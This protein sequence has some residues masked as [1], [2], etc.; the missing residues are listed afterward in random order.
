VIRIVADASVAVKW[1]VRDLSSESYTE[2]ALNLL[3]QVQRREVAL[4][5]PPHWMAEVAAVITRVS[6][7]TAREDIR[8]LH[9]MRYEVV[10]GPSVYAVACDL[11]RELGH[12]LFDT[13]YHA[14][15]L[16]R[17]DTILVTADERYYRKARNRGAIIR[18]SEYES[19]A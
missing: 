6:P 19:P 12:H 16:H 17:D 11:A 1:L 5:Q 3:R 18:L 9:A 13:L 14:V 7:R 8:D 15:A 10:N 4:R 2:Q